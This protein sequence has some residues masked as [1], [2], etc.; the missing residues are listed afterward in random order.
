[1]AFPC[2]AELIHTAVFAAALGLVVAHR[3]DGIDAP[4]PRGVSAGEGPR[5]PSRFQIRRCA[6]FSKSRGNYLE[7]ADAELCGC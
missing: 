7:L 2:G 4:R 3:H 1:M 5:R 6:L